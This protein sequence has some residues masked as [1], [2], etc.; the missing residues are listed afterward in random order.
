MRAKLTGLRESYVPRTLLRGGGIFPSSRGSPF[1]SARP[2]YSLAAQ[3]LNTDGGFIRPPRSRHAQP[4]SPLEPPPP[5]LPRPPS[6]LTSKS[7]LRRQARV[8]GLQQII[9]LTTRGGGRFGINCAMSSTMLRRKGGEGNE[10]APRAAGRPV[11]TGGVGGGTNGRGVSSGWPTGRHLDSV[12][13]RA[14]RRPRG[15][16]VSGATPTQAPC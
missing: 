9:V 4:T 3:T 12:G 16:R 5:P 2:E 1:D 6:R 13:R 14:T 7:Q 15:R 11:D 8:A 10:G